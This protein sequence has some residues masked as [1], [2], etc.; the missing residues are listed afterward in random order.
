M[1]LRTIRND[2]LLKRFESCLEKMDRVDAKSVMADDLE[3]LLTSRNSKAKQE[4]AVS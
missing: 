3:S 2:D 1:V 4:V